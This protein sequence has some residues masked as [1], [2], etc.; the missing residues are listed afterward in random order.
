[1]ARGISSSSSRVP[2]LWLR[3]RLASGEGAATPVSPLHARYETQH[4]PEKHAHHVE[5]TIP[6]Q[7]RRLRPPGL[8]T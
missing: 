6:L 4:A 8:Q 1:M 2:T 7:L 3:S 5:R